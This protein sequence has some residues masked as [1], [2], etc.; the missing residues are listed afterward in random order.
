M[1]VRPRPS[2][3]LRTWCQPSIE[4]TVCVG[5]NPLEPGTINLDRAWHQIQRKEKRRT[6]T[7]TV[8]AALEMKRKMSDLAILVH[9]FG[10]V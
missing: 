6:R 3:M 7:K 10:Y 9:C 1:A 5:E 4:N 2:L 8:K